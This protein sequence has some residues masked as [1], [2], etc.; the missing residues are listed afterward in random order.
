MVYCKTLDLNADG[1][2]ERDEYHHHVAYEVRRLAACA[3][4]LNS[5]AYFWSK[6]VVYSISIY[7]YII[8][9]DDQRLLMI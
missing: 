8:N 9:G 1:Q 4:G 6:S 5:K 7:A 3:C 2:V